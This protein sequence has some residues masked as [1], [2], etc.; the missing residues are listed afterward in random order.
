M[1]QQNKLGAMTFAG[2]PLLSYTI[3][4]AKRKGPTRYPTDPTEL[5]REVAA[6]LGALF[7]LRLTGQG[8]E[9]QAP[10]SSASSSG[11]QKTMARI[12]SL[13]EESCDIGSQFRSPG[14]NDTGSD[15]GLLRGQYGL[16]SD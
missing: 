7:R 16:D 12:V 5:D 1:R 9:V 8:E 15:A 14:S 4:P 10:T 13:C 2:E 6:W 3:T 11:L